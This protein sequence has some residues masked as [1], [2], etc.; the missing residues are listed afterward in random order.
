ME[1]WMILY[2]LAATRKGHQQ[3]SSSAEK[4]HKLLQS[5]TARLLIGE[6][7]VVVKLDGLTR[8]SLL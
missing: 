3:S 6:R 1:G 5:M 4:I 7:T 8:D 2:G